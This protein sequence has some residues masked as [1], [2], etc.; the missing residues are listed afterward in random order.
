MK[1]VNRF[2]IGGFGR[3]DGQVS[4]SEFFRTLCSVRIKINVFSHTVSVP[5][6]KG[7]VDATVGDTILEFEDGTFD[8]LKKGQKDE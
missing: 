2:T 4:P 8:V 5:T 1:I 6:L 3:N 7:Y